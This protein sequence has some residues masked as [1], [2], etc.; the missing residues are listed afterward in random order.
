MTLSDQLQKAVELAR[1]GDVDGA[2]AII[3]AEGQAPDPQAQG[4]VF[5]LLSRSDLDKA[6]RLADRCPEA[7]ESE[8][9][10]SL[11]L[12]RRGLL[13]LDRDDKMRAL[14]DLNQ[15]LRMDVNDDHTEQ[16]RRAMARTLNPD[17]PEDL[18]SAYTVK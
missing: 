4:F 17:P 11:W 6:C 1:Q 3:F 7:A 9:D 12:L 10:R 13:Q 14:V 15:V 16:A 2:L 8:A 18:V 5:M